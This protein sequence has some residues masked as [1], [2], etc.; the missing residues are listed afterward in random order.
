MGKC[1]QASGSQQ[2]AVETPSVRFPFQ[3]PLG[4]WGRTVKIVI[5]ALG[6]RGL[7]FLCAGRGDTLLPSSGAPTRPLHQL[8]FELLML[9]LE[10]N[11]FLR[12]TAEVLALGTF[13]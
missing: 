3:L 4:L 8:E 2:N 5:G 11:F 13:F 9:L 10:N 6:S 1:R 7:A 12:C